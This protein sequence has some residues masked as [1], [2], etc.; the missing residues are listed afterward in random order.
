[1]KLLYL[2]NGPY[3]PQITCYNMQEIELCKAFSDYGWNCDILYYSDE[4]RDEEI[5][6][7][8]QKQTRVEILW[9]KGVDN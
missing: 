1:M 8:E 3:K 2:K 9:R 5:F 7:N 6:Y 4:D